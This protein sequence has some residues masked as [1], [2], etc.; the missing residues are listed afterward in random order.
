MLMNVRPPKWYLFA[1]TILKSLNWL[2][3]NTVILVVAYAIEAVRRRSCIRIL[4]R[5]EATSRR[6]IINRG[7]YNAIMLPAY[8][9]H[10]VNRKKIPQLRLENKIMKISP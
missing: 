4:L 9:L 10:T 7:L 8:E 6:A 5:I 1:V 3:T 2:R